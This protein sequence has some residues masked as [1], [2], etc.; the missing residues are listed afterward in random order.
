MGKATPSSEKKIRQAA[1]FIKAGRKERAYP[2]LREILLKDKNN[3]TAWELLSQATNHKAER[4]YI[5]KQILSIKPG[6]PW[7]RKEL[8]LLEHPISAGDT[9][10]QESQGFGEHKTSLLDQWGLSTPAIQAPLMSAST[11]PASPPSNNPQTRKRRKI[12]LILYFSGALGVLCVG[13]WGYYL[14]VLLGNS[15][16]NSS[17]HM[18]QTAVALQQANCQVLIDEA[19]RSAGTSCDKLSGNSVCYGNFTLQS[20]LVSGSTASFTQRGDIITIQDLKQL[21]ASPLNIINHQW[22][23]AIFKVMANLPRSLPGETV[24]LMLFGNTTLENQSKNLEAFY[25]SSQLGQV[26]CDKVPF[27]GLKIDVPEGSGVQFK[28]NGTELTLTGNASLKANK[29][30]SMDV[31][32][33]SGSGKI[34][35]N[36][37]EQY[38]GAGQKVS[39]TLGGDNG[40]QAISPPSA[41]VPLSPDEIQIAC[42]LY[43]KYCSAAEITP[44]NIDQ[45]KATNQAAFATPTPTQT[46][47]RIPTLSPTP[48]I[49]PSPSTTLTLSQT[50][51]ITRTPT[52]SRTPTRTTTP[53]KTNTPTRT[54]TSGGTILPTSTFSSTPTPSNTLTATST[55]T[56]TPTN[57][58][59][60]TPT[61]TLTTTPT[62]TPTATPTYTITYTPSNTATRTITYTPSNT[63]TYTITHTPTNTAAMTSTATST[64]TPTLTK[65]PT[66]TKTPTI[67]PTPT[68]TL[69]VYINEP[70]TDGTHPTLGQTHFEAQAYDPALGT[71][72]STDN[73]AG[74]SHINFWF[75]DH[76]GNLVVG[77]PSVGSPEIQT[78]VKYC[79]FTGTGTCLHMDAGTYSALN[80]TYT[81]YVQVYAT[82]GAISSIYTRTFIIP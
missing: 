59:G 19:M 32:L 47:T 5:L 41:P 82:S 10:G 23:I 72:F 4:V 27:D 39:V 18:T 2:L 51:T 26:V 69:A 13:I 48:T 68:P 37:Q 12:P 49:S 8:D 14:L 62:E 28:I 6:H 77:L 30:G 40:M 54:A 16:M 46:L 29:G 53:T 21:S 33:Y 81:M 34:V 42:T 70:P 7:A 63:A 67:T 35:S 79:A 44:V 78:S 43:G 60:N 31:S 36:G 58:P 74:I 56:I 38:F 52:M 55:F 1:A 65:T 9:A 17:Q 25:F 45:A 64:K 20:Q 15:R 3:L 66:S 50:G 11:P 73:G 24:T 76:L 71:S 80:D 75:T 22:G 57:T 61:A